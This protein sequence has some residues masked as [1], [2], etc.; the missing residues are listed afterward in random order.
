MTIWNSISALG[1]FKGPVG[2]S[3]STST[4]KRWTRL[5]FNA[6]I[7]IDAVNIRSADWTRLW[8]THLNQR[9]WR[10]RGLPWHLHHF[11]NLTGES[12]LPSRLGLVPWSPRKAEPGGISCVCLML[13]TSVVFAP[14]MGEGTDGHQISRFDEGWTFHFSHLF[15][16]LFV[17][18]DSGN[19]WIASWRGCST[20]TWVLPLLKFVLM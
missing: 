8:V 4:E 5:P 16:Y 9:E 18:G 7:C 15:H 12:V 1:G 14:L 2:Y 3:I 17:R 11:S 10:A 13:L 6:S 20:D 19:T